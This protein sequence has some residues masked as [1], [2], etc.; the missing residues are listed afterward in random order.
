MGMPDAQDGDSRFLLDEF[1][2]DTWFRVAVLTDDEFVAGVLKKNRR[3]TVLGALERGDPPLQ[4]LQQSAS[5]GQGPSAVRLEHV[6]TLEWHADDNL[7]SVGYSDPEKNKSRSLSTEFS[8]SE[9]RAEFVEEIKSTLGTC[10]ER[11]EPASIWHIGMTQ[12]IVSAFAL[13]FCGG[14]AIAGWA[15]P[16]PVDMNKMRAPRKQAI[17]ALYNAVGPTGMAVIGLVVIAAMMVWWYLACRN[18]PLRTTVK[19]L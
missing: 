13:L 15:D 18:P 16:K 19:R 4:A 17:A 6:E 14:L 11:S 7:L 9:M 5:L 3:D 1:T 10:E 12:L 8:S 2:D